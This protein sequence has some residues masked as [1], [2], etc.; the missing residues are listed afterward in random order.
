MFTRIFDLHRRAEREE[1]EE[2]M[3]QVEQTNEVSEES[4]TMPMRDKDDNDDTYMLP[5]SDFDLTFPLLADVQKKIKEEIKLPTALNDKDK[6]SALK[7]SQDKL[8]VEHQSRSFSSAT[9]ASI[10]ANAPLHPFSKV[11]YFEITISSVG[12]E[13][14][15]AIGLAEKSYPSNKQPG[16]KNLSYAY[17]GDDGRKFHNRASG[18]PYGP[19]FSTGDTVGCGLIFS[20]RE[21][22]FTKNGVILGKA[23]DNVPTNVDLYPIIGLDK[24]KAAVN[25]G[26]EPFKFKKLSLLIEEEKAREQRSIEAIDSIGLD[27]VRSLVRS[28]LIHHGY[29]DTLAKLDNGIADKSPPGAVTTE[30]KRDSYELALRKGKYKLSTS[31]HH[32]LVCQHSCFLLIALITLLTP[33]TI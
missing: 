13:G 23:F 24:A 2:Y 19:K 14:V 5:R 27:T 33:A 32:H 28:Y 29:A 18:L 10:K 9:D 20:K 21:I 12:Y 11:G 1:E 26:A 16:W 15:V 6:N 3:M 25:F 4:A 17:H 8:F 22:F 7:L 31:S 30:S